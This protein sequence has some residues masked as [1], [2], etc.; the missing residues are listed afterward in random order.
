MSRKAE[1][2]AGNQDE[3][4]TFQFINRD[5]AL[6]DPKTKRKFDLEMS[7]NGRQYKFV[8]GKI[9]TAPRDV[10]E[11]L[12]GKTGACAYPVYGT[13]KD[14][15]GNEVVQQIS[16]VPRFMCVEVEL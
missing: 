2:S 15:D 11:H 1:F 10:F 8:D 5:D 6:T 4:V 14:D 3:M 13:V 9:H 7:Y 16:S 12:N